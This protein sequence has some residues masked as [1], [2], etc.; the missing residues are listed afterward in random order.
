RWKRVTMVRR[1]MGRPETE[2]WER[3]A[4][5]FAH[6]E[7]REPRVAFANVHQVY[8]H[9]A[10]RR[11]PIRPAISRAM[12]HA[13]IARDINNPAKPTNMKAKLK[14]QRLAWLI[15]FVRRAEG[16]KIA[17]EVWNVTVAWR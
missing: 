1:I 12:V 13:V 4:L 7:C 3:I 10:F 6:A 5:A 9:L 11:S 15:K 17:E 8:R 14:Q 16:P 2:F